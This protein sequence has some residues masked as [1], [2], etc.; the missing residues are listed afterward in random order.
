MAK[1]KKKEAKKDK[2]Q[3]MQMAFPGGMGEEKVGG[4]WDSVLLSLIPKTY[5]DIYE[6]GMAIIN[7]AQNLDLSDTDTARAMLVKLLNGIGSVV[8]L[9][10]PTSDDK[11]YQWA[12]VVIFGVDP[13]KTEAVPNGIRMMVAVPD[14]DG[15]LVAQEMEGIEAG[16]DDTP[17]TIL[18][19]VMKHFGVEGKTEAEIKKKGVGGML[20]WLA[21]QQLVKLILG[22]LMEKAMVEMPG[23]EAEEE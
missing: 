9:T 6:A 12:C 2:S 22:R 18:A 4:I 19:K 16:H 21:I 5:R 3:K 17:A 8:I 7:G 20:L 11:Y 1:D 15:Q 23:E 13:V 10:K 14:E